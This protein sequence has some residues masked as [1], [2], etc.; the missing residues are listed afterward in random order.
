MGAM[1]VHIKNTSFFGG[2]LAIFP[3]KKPLRLAETRW[4][5]LAI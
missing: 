1:D 2:F 3:T 5:P 4:K